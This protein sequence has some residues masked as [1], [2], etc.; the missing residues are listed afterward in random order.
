MNSYNNNYPEDI[1]IKQIKLSKIQNSPH[2][3]EYIDCSLTCKI[4]NELF[5]NYSIMTTE[6][7]QL[8]VFKNIILPNIP[9]INPD[10]INQKNNSTSIINIFENGARS[11]FSR[12]KQFLS[13]LIFIDNQKISIQEQVFNDI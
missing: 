6:K 5:W 8:N 13:N 1:V 12:H 11:F 3:G 2:A 10:L 9:K 4:I 7:S